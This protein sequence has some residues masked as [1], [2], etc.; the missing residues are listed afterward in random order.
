MYYNS[1]ATLALRI[2]FKAYVMKVVFLN[3]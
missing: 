3:N 1:Q 2:L